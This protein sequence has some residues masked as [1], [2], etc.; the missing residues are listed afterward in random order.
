[1]KPLP[2]LTGAAGAFLVLTLAWNCSRTPSEEEPAESPEAAP[3]AETV[4]EARR[5]RYQESLDTLF[6]QAPEEVVDVQTL[7]T[8]GFESN[9]VALPMDGTWREHPCLADLD[10]DGRADLVASNREENGLNIWKSVPGEAWI[11]K[12]EGVSDDLM[13]GGSDCGDLDG[14]G[15][16]DVLFASHNQGLRAFL[17]DG[18]MNWTEVVPTADSTFLALDVALGNLNGDD[19]LDAVTIAQFVERGRGALGVYF[20]KGDGSF[21]IQQPYREVTLPSR[22]GVQ[23]EL[24]DITGDGLDE[25]FLTAEKGCMIFVPSISDDGKVEF[26][27]HSRGL[28]L[29]PYNMGNS[30]RSM[31]PIDVEGDGVWEVA[32]GSLVNPNKDI[33]ERYSLGVLRWNE[34]AESWEPFGEGL[35]DGKAYSDVMAADYNGDGHSDLLVIGTGVGASIYLG[36]GKGKF[37][38]AGML[39]GTLAGGR[40]A[41]G[42]IDGDGKTDVVVICGATKSRPD[43]GA[44]RTFLNRDAAWTE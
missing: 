24:Q 27:N 10:G 38:A 43:A 35:P 8:L 37:E 6:N 28:P 19:H 18:E 11:E 2:T 26:S 41:V 31:V 42:D 1:M 44:V 14:D 17:N 13:Y 22:F 12:R 36:D 25:V 29:P 3:D 15:D 4:E 7:P 34:E 23:A 16:V 40:G 5:R 20:G 30:L 33:E 32:F 9:S 21:E 39:E